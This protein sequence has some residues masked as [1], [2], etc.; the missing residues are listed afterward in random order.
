M[1][2]KQPLKILFLQWNGIPLAPDSLR[3]KSLGGS[4]TALM[5][6]ALSLSRRGHRVVVYSKL[7]TDRDFELEGVKFREGLSF[8]SDKEQYDIAVVSRDLSPLSINPVQA[9]YTVYWLHDMPADG[10]YLEAQ[11]G[12]FWAIDKI[13]VLSKFQRLAWVKKLE[14]IKYFVYQTRNGLD[15]KLLNKIIPFKKAKARNPY[16]LMYISRP[17]RGLQIL[18]EYIWP[19]IIRKEPRMQLY[20]CRYDS[21]SNL[22]TP[23]LRQLYAHLDNLVPKLPGV[24]YLGNLSKAKLYEELKTCAALV[25]P[26]IWPE[27]SCIAAMEAMACGAPVVTTHNF[28]LP[29]T[30][31]PEY[32]GLVR[33]HPLQAK[34]Q[35]TFVETL[36]R[37]IENPRSEELQAWARQFD[38]E[39]IAEEWEKFFIDGLTVKGYT[40]WG[41]NVPR[42]QETVAACLLVKDEEENI[43]GCLR[44]AAPC[45]DEIHITDTGSN[46][47]TL[48][49]VK[50]F[51]QEES[52][53]PIYVHHRDGL[54]HFDDARNQSVSYT[55]C[56]WILWI[57]A[58]ERLIGG[59]N[60]K[61]YLRSVFFPGFVIKQHHFYV[62]AESHADNPVRLYRNWKLSLPFVK[63]RFRAINFIGAIHEHVEFGVNEVVYPVSDISEINIAHFGYL[64]EKI[65]RTKVR[66]RNL[67]LL[68]EDR[69]KW[70]DRLM[71]RVLSM[72][73]LFHMFVWSLE[74]ETLNPEYLFKIIRT[75]RDFFITM[76]YNLDH[77]TQRCWTEAFRWYQQALEMC[78]RHNITFENKS[79]FAIKIFVSAGFSTNLE[80]PKNFQIRWFLFEK[81]LRD[82]LDNIATKV[83]TRLTYMKVGL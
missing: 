20:I 64:S 30:L 37:V 6:M 24:T 41:E 53:V 72:R 18:L 27:I 13:F 3:S 58:D 43:L 49:I 82:Y 23:E 34:Y 40:E 17:E 8:L 4:E 79:P 31:P 1:Q 28:A 45:V 78:A 15:W 16:K 42:K 9:K 50:T 77:N 21:P 81:E 10:E 69:K 60:I 74:N 48:D 54:G 59:E 22:L 62:D 80:N 55:E 57:D 11:L 63:E 44:K 75:Y 61:Q 67:K 83:L 73:D 71:G 47:K 38:W 7:A 66:D 25:Y 12:N 2:R 70:P 29:E 33:G 76:E 56:D 39:K 14:H 46:D 35:E 26:C 51:A 65:R 52:P 5:Q 36:F 68:L 32:E 19:M